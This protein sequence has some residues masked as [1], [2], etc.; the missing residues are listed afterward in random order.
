MKIKN[1]FKNIWEKIKKSYYIS[2]EFI[3]ENKIYFIIG[4]SSVLLFIILLF[5]LKWYISLLITLIIDIITILVCWKRGMFVK[6]KK[7]INETKKTKVKKIK[8]KTEPTY[9]KI[10]RF[11]LIFFCILFLIGLVAVGAFFTYIV[12]TT[13]KFDEKKLYKTE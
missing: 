13:E 11:I 3:L 1:F 10:L 12:A 7:R 9:K 8:K 6:K 5:F 4:L 2:Y